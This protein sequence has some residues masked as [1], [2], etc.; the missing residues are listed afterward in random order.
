MDGIMI[1]RSD[2]RN[3]CYR[4]KK[5]VAEEKHKPLLDM[6][7]P[8]LQPHQRWENFPTTWDIMIKGSDIKIVN[9]E[10]DYDF[11]HSTLLEASLCDRRGIKFDS[12]TFNDRQLNIITIVE[13]LMLD[14][15]MTWSNY[16]KVWG[17]QIDPTIKQIQTTLYNYK[18]AQIEV[19]ED[20]IK[21]SMKDA[22]GT[23]LSEEHIKETVLEMKPMSAAVKKDF[24]KFLAKK[25]KG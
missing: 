5:G 20:M 13:V 7:E 16:N 6:I 17:V 10:T 21:A 24:D 2:L 19:T 3:A 1:T 4:A 15:V 12:E 11:I 8:L 22:D 25:K 23:P 9:A 18:S 14:N